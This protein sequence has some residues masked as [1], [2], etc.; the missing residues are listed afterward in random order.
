MRGD[1]RGDFW[2]FRFEVF[3]NEQIRQS[4]PFSSSRICVHPARLRLDFFKCKCPRE[5]HLP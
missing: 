1:L 3:E 5:P 2:K 4:I